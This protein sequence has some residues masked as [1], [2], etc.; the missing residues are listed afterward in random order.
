MSTQGA[1]I[2]KKLSLIMVF[3]L[4]L[5]L[6]ACGNNAEMVPKE[7]YDAVVEKLEKTEKELAQVQEE[8]IELRT[9]IDAIIVSLK[10]INE[11]ETEVENQEATEKKEDEGITT[12]ITP[13][14]VPDP[15]TQS[16]F[17]VEIT[18]ENFLS[19]FEFIA[20]NEYNRWGEY[21]SSKKCGF[22]SLLYEQGWAIGK[23][24]NFA[25][26][27]SVFGY[28]KTTETQPINSAVSTGVSNE[29]AEMDL[30]IY[31]VEGT[32]TFYPVKDVRDKVFTSI[33]YDHRTIDRTLPD[34]SVIT[35]YT[36]VDGIM[37]Y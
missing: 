33:E 15:T 17:V 11:K 30:R 26:E 1:F 2:M 7:N 13:I 23:I 22:S 5:S 25:V 28:P 8:V 24:D 16:E 29:N 21:K 19:I 18:A 31:R 35:I 12:V 6:I 27:Y 36:D 37:V 9:E 14:T 32:I 3:I 10:K 20:I 4:T 34:G